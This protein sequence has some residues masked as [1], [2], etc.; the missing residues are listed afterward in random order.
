MFGQPARL[1]QRGNVPSAAVKSR[2]KR[3]RFKKFFLPAPEELRFKRDSRLSAIRI[4]I[5]RALTARPGHT[6]LR[7]AERKAPDLILEAIE[8]IF[9]SPGA[10]Q[11]D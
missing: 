6:A 9:F 5:C 10:K 11:T 8:E 2:F 7:I 4:L 1:R 3:R